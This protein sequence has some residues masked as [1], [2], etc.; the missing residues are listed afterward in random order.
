MTDV[1]VGLPVYNDPDG[2]R[3][4][5]PTVFSQTWG[6]RVRLLVIDDGS[7]DGTPAVLEELTRRYRDIE[8][9]R[10]ERNQG[11]PRARNQVLEHAGDGYLAWI[12]SDDLWHPRKLELQFR[13][14]EEARAG[15]PVLCTCPIRFAWLGRGMRRQ[16]PEI[17]GDQLRNALTGELHPYLW[18]MLGRAQDFRDAGGFNERLPRRQ[19][20]EFLVRF[21]E[22]GGRVVSTAGPLPLA[23]YIKSDVGRSP[24]EV[25]AS[26][27]VIAREHQDTFRRYGRRFARARRAE[28][29]LLVA[30]Y[31]ENNG[32]MGFAR[33]YQARAHVYDP[34]EWLVRTRPAAATVRVARRAAALPK[35]ATRATPPEVRTARNRDEGGGIRPLTT[36]R[37]L[38]DAGEHHRAVV[39]LEEVLGA[40]GDP[41]PPEAWFLLSEAHRGQR[42]LDR[43]AEAL[44]RG[45]DAHPGSEELLVRVAELEAI[46]EEW[47]SAIG[48]WATIAPLE[49]HHTPRTYLLLARAHRATGDHVGAHRLAAAGT[50]RFPK[51]LPLRQELAKARAA[52][53]DWSSAVH[54][55]APPVPTAT[56]ED[57]GGV[58]TELG[59]LVG[60]DAALEGRVAPTATRAPMVSL[61]VNGKLIATT[62]AATPSPGEGGTFSFRCDMMLEF[63]GDGDIVTVD[64]ERRPLSF[65][66]VGSRAVVLTGYPGRASELLD[67]VAAGHV[68]TKFGR[69]RQGNTATRKQRTLALFDDVAGHIERE[70]DA[71]AHPFYGN[72]LGAIRDNDFIKHDVGGFDMGYVSRHTDP[73]AVKAEFL[74]LC[75]TLLDRGYDLRLDPWCAMVREHPADPYFVDVNYGWFSP[76]GELQLSFGWRYPP[77]TDRDSFEAPRSNP[78]GGHL[79]AVPGNAE[80]VLEQIY[81]PDWPVPDQ[82]FDLDAQLR[83]D[84]RYLLT[85]EELEALRDTCP[86]RVRIDNVFDDRGEIVAYG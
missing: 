69:L 6:G 16:K 8:V 81:G 9:V 86:E 30:R 66:G 82:G 24:R 33:L 43:A 79:V 1:T 68:F 31:H 46:R 74:G 2:L 76:D 21:L 37:E 35:R 80:Q 59:F 77:V 51:D 48:R 58:V 15:G 45:L 78:I 19:D 29:M 27:K 13:A 41:Q 57:T 75:R 23:T 61:R 5:V 44:E 83:R 32:Q 7:T 26:N 49:E 22:R 55:T 34:V 28:R 53:V 62:H 20:Y 63:L 40:A 52:L 11:R 73:E 85:A 17:G 25:A 3:R 64:C 10:N 39:L 67:R 47:T 56:S 84:L 70:L 42:D 12:D 72:L 36:A 14:L 50:A 65:G 38:L 71:T 18:S 60:R 4:S 54:V